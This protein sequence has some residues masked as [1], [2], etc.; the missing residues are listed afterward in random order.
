[1]SEEDQVV[2]DVSK[3]SVLVSLLHPLD[4]IDIY[5]TRRRRAQFV[6][7]CNKPMKDYLSCGLS[8]FSP[9]EYALCSPNSL[10]RYLI[11]FF[12]SQTASFPSPSTFIGGIPISGVRAL[13]LFNI[14][15]YL[16]ISLLL[17]TVLLS[18]VRQ[19][20]SESSSIFHCW[21]FWSSMLSAVGP[22][23]SVLSGRSWLQTAW[24]RM[25]LFVI[26]AAQRGMQWINE[27][28]VNVDELEKL[29][30]DAKG[31]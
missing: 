10:W 1:M 13:I 25:S 21:I 20:V 7:M 31:A 3:V 6:E 8:S 17:F 12:V 4:L 15:A 22:I 28:E 9:R 2:M 27:V 29:K 23:L 24:W 5:R 19:H 16:A 30:Y 11:D 14:S 26:L 18:R